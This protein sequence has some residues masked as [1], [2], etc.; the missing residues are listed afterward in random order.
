MDMVSMLRLNIDMKSSGTM[1]SI[2]VIAQRFGL[3]THV[4]RHW[5]SMGLLTPTRVSGQRRYT[6]DDP[7]RVAAILR[8]K[9]AGLSLGQIRQMITT[10]DPAR[11]AAI[12]RER[13]DE[14]RHRI[15]AAQQ[16]LD[17]IE[18]VLNCRHQDFTRCPRYREA[19][20]SWTGT[21][22]P[23]HQHVMPG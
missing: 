11:R 13:R 21:D 6:D 12:L 18:R 14:L 19:V 7:Y 9:Q 10:T 2:G 20:A 22:E 15:A 17:L 5:E 3:A 8:A 23:P 1:L 16:A 4:L